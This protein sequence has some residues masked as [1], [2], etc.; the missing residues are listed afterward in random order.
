V[1]RN[2]SCHVGPQLRLELFIDILDAPFRAEHDK[3]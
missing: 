3:T 2:D 1:I